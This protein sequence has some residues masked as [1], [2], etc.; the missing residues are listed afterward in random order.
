MEEKEPEVAR[1]PKQWVLVVCVDILVIAELCLAMYYSSTYSDNFE[2][3]FMKSFFGMLL[4]TLILA[5]LGK[6]FLHHRVMKMS[7]NHS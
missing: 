6:R 3:S 4:P 5:Y 7:T 2:L 1:H